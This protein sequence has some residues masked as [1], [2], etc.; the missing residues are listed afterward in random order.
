MKKLIVLILLPISI[1]C[2]VTDIDNNTYQTTVINGTEW[3]AENLRV[4][5]FNDGQVI[6]NVTSD[7]LWGSLTT[8]AYC[9]PLND[10]TNDLI[11]G[12]IYNNYVASNQSNICPVGWRIPTIYEIQELI[13]YV[14]SIYPNNAAYH[15]KSTTD[16]AN[17]DNGLNTFG[18]N[19]KPHGFR[20]PSFLMFG[21]NFNL[22][23]VTLDSTNGP[24]PFPT[25]YG[26]YHTS[27]D[28]NIY[29]S[30]WPRNNGEGLRCIK[31]SCASNVTIYDTVTVYD[32]ITYYDTV[33][34]Y[35]TITYYDTSYLSIS[36]TDT[37]YI[38]ITVTGVPNIDNTISVYPNPAS[39]VVIIDNGNYSTM[40][41]YSL[42][43]VNSLLQQVFSSQINTQQFQIPVSTLGAV[44]TYFVQIFDG[45][46]NLVI[47]KYLVLN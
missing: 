43:I 2:Q 9:F 6:P 44:G 1:L 8:P 18:F 30:I 33:T 10:S 28:N 26:V 24:P 19:A 11:Y 32:T 13:N 47:I 35:D 39:G 38:D 41:N 12:K 29:T 16:W 37:L 31:A 14:D 34:L 17:G 7:N 5:R 36:V 4:K 46:N 25:A 21:T 45:N 42:V 22:W 27:G 23:G 40:S 20:A 3:M 15:L